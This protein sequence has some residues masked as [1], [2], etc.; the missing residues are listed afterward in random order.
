M[1]SKELTGTAA[2]VTGASSGIGA[3][4][5]R[6]LAELGAGE[7]GLQV[8]DAPPRRLQLSTLAR[9]QSGLESMV[10]ARLTSPVVHR[11]IADAEAARHITHAPPCREQIKT[12]RSFLS[13][14]SP[15]F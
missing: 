10:N 9:G 5:A 7:L 11:L 12:G 13:C 15:T 3:A 8:S 4:T 6:Q 1:T 14:L 2:L